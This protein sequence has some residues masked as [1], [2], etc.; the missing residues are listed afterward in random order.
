M[1]SELEIQ[2]LTVQQIEKQLNQMREYEKQR[3]DS[4]RQQYITILEKQIQQKRG[5]DLG[6]HRLK[7]SSIYFQNK[8]KN[9]LD[10]GNQN[11]ISLDRYYR[12]PIVPGLS[13][14][15]DYNKQLQ[16]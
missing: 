13:P 7:N 11:L 3:K 6:S 14:S 8:A 9:S 15:N 2:K 1:K 16:K 4:Y 10:L 12:T 5:K